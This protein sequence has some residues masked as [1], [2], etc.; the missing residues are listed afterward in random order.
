MSNLEKI[1]RNHLIWARYRRMMKRLAI[2]TL[3][4][5]IAVFAVLWKLDG[6]LPIHFVIAS[7]LGVFLMVMLTVG[8]M[9]LVFVSSSTD[10]DDDVVDPTGEQK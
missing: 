2:G 5:I 1:Y 9:G 8:L 10:H 7:T 3:L 6:P 4:F